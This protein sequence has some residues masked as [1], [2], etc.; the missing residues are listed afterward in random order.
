[1]WKPTPS[2]RILDTLDRLVATQRNMPVPL[3]EQE[4][5]DLRDAAFAI[6]QIQVFCDRYEQ[7]DQRVPKGTGHVSVRAVLAILD[8]ATADEAYR[9]RLT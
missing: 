6:R 1:M 2:A 7:R 5:T 8:G 4:H 9:D 3:T